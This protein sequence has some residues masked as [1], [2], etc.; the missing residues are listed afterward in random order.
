VGQF[1]TSGPRPEPE[2]KPKPAKPKE[3]KA[4]WLARLQAQI[5]AHAEAN[6]MRMSD[7][8][9]R[10][11]PV[12][13]KSREKFAEPKEV[14]RYRYRD[15]GKYCESEQPFREFGLGISERG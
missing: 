1:V 4:E 2:P 15:I 5:D 12:R 13:P 7:P 6:C 9:R 8:K 10:Y 14:R 3:P 11:A